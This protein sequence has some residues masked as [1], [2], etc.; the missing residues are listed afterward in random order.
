MCSVSIIG[1]IPQQIDFRRILDLT[2]LGNIV[3]IKFSL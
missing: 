1:Y 2:K 3:C